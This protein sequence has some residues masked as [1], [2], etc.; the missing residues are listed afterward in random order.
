MFLEVTFRFP[1]IEG[2]SVDFD[3]DVDQ[4]GEDFNLDTSGDLILR[5]VKRVAHLLKLKI[6]IKETRLSD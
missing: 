6:Y 4:F 5:S 1:L 2:E 3:G